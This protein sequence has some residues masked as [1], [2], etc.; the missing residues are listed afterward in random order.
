MLHDKRTKKFIDRWTQILI[1][2]QIVLH[3]VLLVGLLCLFLFAEPFVTMFSRYS[4]EDH[5]AIA[6]ELILLNSSKWP[7]FLFLALFTGA[8]S[9]VFSHQIVGPIFKTN[10]IL[11]Q[12]GQRRL[13][14]LARFR[15]SDYFRDLERQLNQVIETWKG[16]LSSV[17]DLQKRAQSLVDELK[18]RPNSPEKLKELEKI[19]ASL[20]E[21]VRSYEI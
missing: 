15:K 5:V 3:S 14:I 6:K 16:D 8:V 1:G 9:V 18:N 4:A 2:G 7:L 10:L 19:L 11:S 20:A 12:L 21:L 13:G 17:A